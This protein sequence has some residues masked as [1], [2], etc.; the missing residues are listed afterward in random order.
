MTQLGDE[1]KKRRLSREL[2]LTGAAKLM[3]LKIPEVCAI[4]FGREAIQ[5]EALIAKL[6]KLYDIPVDKLE[7]LNEEAKKEVELK[8]SQPPRRPTPEEI[9]DMTRRGVHSWGFVD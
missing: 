5:S 9:A 3:G 7:A 1:L 4:E 8:K 2:S 6:S